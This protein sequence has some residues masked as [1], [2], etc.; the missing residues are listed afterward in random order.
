MCTTRTLWTDDDGL[1]WRDTD[2]IGDDFV[3][4]G[5][6]LYW[7]L[8]GEL[9]VISD[10]PPAA[11]GDA[12]EARLAIAVPN[13]TIVEAIPIAAGSPRSSRTGSP[14]ATGTPS[15]ACSSRTVTRYGRSRSHP[16]LRVRYSPSR[17]LPTART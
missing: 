1:V 13:G 15:R 16:R 14:G 6:D 3:G 4:S 7:W 12:L 2:R 11:G 5:S 8:G 17:L 10:F 9:H